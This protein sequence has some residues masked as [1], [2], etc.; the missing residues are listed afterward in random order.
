MEVIVEFLDGDPD[1]PIVTGCV[2][3][4][5][6][7]TPYPLPEHKTRSTF[8]TKT[9]Q[10][11]GFNEL[12]FEDEK[13]R[14]EIY[15]HAQKDR[16][17]KV[18]NNQSERVNVNKVESVGHSRASEVGNHRYDI[19]GGD[20]ELSV[21]PSQSG[22]FTPSG[23]DRMIEGVGGVPYGLGNPG[24]RQKGQGN[25]TINVEK[26]LVESVGRNQHVRIGKN[27][28]EDIA[29]SY[30]L[31]VGEELQIDVGKKIT[32]KCGQSVLVLQENGSITINGQTITQT[33]DQLIR[34]L[35][36]VVKI[37]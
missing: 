34:L 5:K 14:E 21:G 10:G 8:K 27:R 18:E 25:L 16:N 37:N 28:S 19:V 26:D 36:D 2:Y 23:A 13:G 6:N 11:D 15:V 29:T 20:M 17:T 24:K 32:L 3:N 22:R 7:D 31:D 9:H 1:K 4:G 33:A 35:A 30:F 12:R